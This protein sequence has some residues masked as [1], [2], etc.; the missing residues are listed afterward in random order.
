MR[1]SLWKEIQEDLIRE[2]FSPKIVRLGVE[3]AQGYLDTAKRISR[4]P[5]GA[6]RNWII[7]YLQGLE[8]R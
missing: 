7:N 2:G 3:W 1:K 8:R 4:D 5:K 6:V